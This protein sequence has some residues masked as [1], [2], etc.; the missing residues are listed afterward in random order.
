MP[1]PHSD[2]NE[3]LPRF[4]EALESIKDTQRRGGYE[5]VDD[6]VLD[7]IGGM[8]P[9]G[10][11]EQGVV[12]LPENYRPENGPPVLMLQPKEIHSR[13]ILPGT[14]AEIATAT[15]I[16]QQSGVSASISKNYVHR[17]IAITYGDAG[18]A[19]INSSGIGFT[20]RGEDTPYYV[21]LPQLLSISPTASRKFM[22]STLAHEGDHWDF[23]L[24]S[25]I[26]QSNPQRRYTPTEI[27]AIAEKRAY[28]T[29]H[30]IEQNLGYHATHLSVDAIA[31]EH[32]HLA[33]AELGKQLHEHIYGSRREQID[34]ALAVAA[35]AKILG[36][37]DMLITPEEITAL[38]HL[39]I[40]P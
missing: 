8:E 9:V 34:H 24:N 40:I 3:R 20:P 4:R 30:I 33:P 37:S 15:R 39:E 2:I 13:I 28:N 23:D 31:E 1:R 18:Q 11:D 10:L 6:A 5:G 21:F 26:L 19:S 14:E 25:G 36:D 7:C 38:Q 32:A 16:A 27:D 35:I 22:G 29:T 17:S 12:V